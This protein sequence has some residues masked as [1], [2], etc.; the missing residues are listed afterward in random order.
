MEI[1]LESEVGETAYD[2]ALHRI[3]IDVE[4]LN[5]L[6]VIDPVTD[7]IIDRNILP[8]CQEN[9][10]LLLDE[11]Q[12]LALVVCETNSALLMVDLRSMRVL[13]NQPV[14]AGPVF[15]ALDSGL[16]YLYA[17]S[18]RWVVTVFDERGRVLQALSQR[19]VAFAVHSIVVDPITRAM[20]V[21]LQNVGGNSILKIALFQH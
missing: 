21:P 17:V 4:R 16:L 19:Y 15:M 13:F 8:G 11:K 20:Y 1:P 3:L 14:G 12:S 5:P 6:V 18:E 2:S 9:Q 10:S 7:E